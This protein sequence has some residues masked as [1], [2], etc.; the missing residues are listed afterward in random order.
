MGRYILLMLSIFIFTFAQEN[1]LEKVKL[2]LQ[3]K[4]QFQFAG[5]IMA[6]EKGYYKDFGLDVEILEYNN[7]NIMKDVESGRVD[8]GVNN[9][10]LSFENR[11]LDDISLIATYF[12][13][14]P[15]IILVQPEIKTPNDLLGKTLMMTKSNIY[16]GSLARLL[17]HFNI[18][19]NTANYIE[20]T[21]DIND[22]IDRKVDG[23]AAFRSNELY[24][25]EKMG[26]D[27]NVIDPAD[28]GFS[29]N[30]INLF[31]SHKKID[32]NPDQ[33]HRFLE[34]TKQGWRYAIDNIEQSAKIIHEK[35]QPNKSVDHL[36]Y[37]GRISKELML[38]KLFDIGEIDKQ[39]ILK[40][41]KQL[42]NLGLI[43][44]R[45]SNERLFYLEN[46]NNL[47]GIIDFTAEELDW[48]KENPVV[49]YSEINWKPLSIIEDNRMKGIMGDYLDIVA[50]KTNLKFRFIPSD[51][52]FHVLEQFKERKIDLV[53]GVGS[54]PQELELGS[55]SRMYAKYP[56]VIVTDDSFTYLDN[57]NDLK[58][59]VV[60][61]PQHYTSYN[62]IVEN[63]PDIKLI[64]TKNIPEAL[65]L[66]EEKKADAFVG[67]I[68]TSLYYLSELHLQNLKVSGITKFEFE[69]HY[70]VQEDNPILLSIINKTFD[71]IT[72]KERKE[73]YSKW[74]QT[75]KV[76]RSIDYTLT[77]LVTIFF[78]IIIA[79]IIFWMKKLKN[80]IKRRKESEKRL[81]ISTDKLMGLYKLS[82]LGIALIDMDGKFIEF[83]D[84]FVK[85]C[86]YSK[87]ELLELDSRILTPKEY[88]EEENRQLQYL[89]K[90]SFFSSYEKEFIQKD[91]TLIPIN[92]N[93]MLITNEDGK[94]YVW[95]IVEDIS[96]RKHNE[97]IMAQQSSL[98]AMGEMIGNIAHQWRQPLSVISTGA[99]GLKMQK[100]FGTLKDELFF[101]TCDNINENAQYLSKTIDDFRNFIKGDRHKD[102]F[103]ICDV[104]DS[105]LN[106]VAGNIK[107]HE[108]EVELDLV[109]CTKL[110]G[111]SNEL[112]QCFMNIF[113][114]AKDALDEIDDRRLLFISSLVEDEFLVIKIKDNG[115]GIATDVLPKIFEPYFTTKHQSQGTGLGLH[116]TYNLIV[117]GM[118]G[119][120]LATNEKYNYEGVEYLGA[121]FT[122]KIPLS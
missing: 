122:I 23:V 90:N 48:I 21:F 17:N 93:G 27:Y 81:K 8:F 104:V 113:N 99:T 68:A 30:A 96:V 103:S 5:F 2:Q 49:S 38:L 106:L 65:L 86:G 76:E 55:I 121:Q 3:W 100:E 107:R 53:P 33:V 78:I 62:F 31:T 110:Y 67:H 105:F 1:N 22:F 80:E 28:Y 95:S 59:K 115:G 82:P 101:S 120:I 16:S 14:S 114:N 60:A 72:S 117:D 88:E 79:L 64:T 24:L 25:L 43:D 91:G 58:D 63:Y 84:S 26:I 74:V 12:Q 87:E 56:M 32:T 77:I 119:S 94:K 70:L 97:E 9:T 52:W 73:I 41:F 57:L 98:V 47:S 36:I 19:E 116:M 40:R 46:K 11:K 44:E 15:Y 18:N 111:F 37:E 75:T 45:Q 51:S 50:K 89:L 71:S 69:H 42:I 13:R 102:Y 92:L 109:E 34:A 7:T 10:L 118:K 83:N 20:P 29:T 61:V 39:F 85:I 54:S 108:I 66:V 35:Y 6:K 4:F 112:I